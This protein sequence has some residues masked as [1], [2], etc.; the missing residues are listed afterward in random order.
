[1]IAEVSR[2][3]IYV[4]P[5]FGDE[6][7]FGLLE[8][9]GGIT[10]LLDHSELGL[11]PAGGD[12]Y[13]PIVD[14]GLWRLGDKALVRKQPDHRV[15]LVELPRVSPYLD[16]LN[17][18]PSAVVQEHRWTVTAL[19]EI[20]AGEAVRTLYHRRLS[21]NNNA[22]R[23]Y[24]FAY[25][26]VQDSIVLADGFDAVRLMWHLEDNHLFAILEEEDEGVDHEATE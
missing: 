22:G 13:F 6:P 16:I 1:M 21:D 20:P 23:S 26:L 8:R 25:F 3:Y 18:Y 24:E 5:A 7:R 9:Q 14:A 15:F 12:V 19:I 10:V 11:P 4:E 2:S 17:H